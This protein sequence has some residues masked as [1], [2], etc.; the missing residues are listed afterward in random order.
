MSK[1]LN[2]KVD[3]KMLENPEINEA[4]GIVER[5]A[6]TEADIYVYEDYLLELKTQHNSVENARKEGEKQKAVSIARNLK[7][8]G[9][10]IDFIA[11]NTGLTVDEILKL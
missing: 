9:L 3:L 5:S 4:L 8:A 7:V 6:Y 1:Y 10:D 2:R 11:E